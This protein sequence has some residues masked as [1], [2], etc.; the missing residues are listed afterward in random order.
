MEAWNGSHGVIA[1]PDAAMPFL[2]P[3]WNG[4]GRFRVAKDAGLG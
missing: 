1:P 4:R 3:P 2:K